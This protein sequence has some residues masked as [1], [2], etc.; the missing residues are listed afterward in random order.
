MAAQDSAVYQWIDCSTNQIIPCE[1][2]R[3]FTPSL[4][5]NYK[6]NI[7]LLSC[8]TESDCVFFGTT[9]AKDPETD[10]E[11][12]LLTKIN[13][14]SYACNKNISSAL[15][16]STDGKSIP[17]ATNQHVIHLTGINRGIYILQASAEGHSLRRKIIVVK[18]S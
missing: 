16:F 12:I 2:N 9:S 11:N 10:T 4:F 13:A 6:V 18:V 8:M 7:S 17:L 15:L 5:G 1:T 14:T 3:L